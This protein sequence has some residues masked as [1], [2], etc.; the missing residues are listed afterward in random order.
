MTS[1]VGGEA[2]SCWASS[3]ASRAVAVGRVR[4]ADAVGVGE[5]E[6]DAVGLAVAVAAEVAL[7]EALTS[8]SA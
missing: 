6:A 7:V 2:A 3:D 1:R 8:A 5:G 4:G